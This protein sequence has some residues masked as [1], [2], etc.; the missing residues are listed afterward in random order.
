MIPSK[1]TFW[2]SGVK[3]ARLP[4]SRI[5]SMS[6]PTGFPCFS[7]SKGGYAM[8]EAT[9]ICLPPP[10]PPPPSTAAACQDECDPRGQALPR[11]SRTI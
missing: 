4:I 7:N 10:P 1:A 8:S 5:R 11:C 9:V 3:P 2:N 6:K